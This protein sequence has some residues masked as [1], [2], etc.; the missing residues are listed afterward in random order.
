VLSIDTIPTPDVETVAQL[1]KKIKREKQARRIV[2]AIR[3]GIHSLY[4]EAEP[5]W[6]D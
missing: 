1:F 3:R 4:L 2:F 5:A 6:V